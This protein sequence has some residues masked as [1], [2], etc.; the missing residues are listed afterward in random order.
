[1]EVAPELS[2]PPVG[3]DGVNE[4]VDDDEGTGEDQ[5]AQMVGAV[6]ARGV[7]GQSG[8]AVQPQALQVVAAPIYPAPTNP[9]HLGRLGWVAGV[10][11][12]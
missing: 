11:P 6:G 7:G 10:L 8:G 9:L 1:M 5:D 4:Q 2:D 3:S 12:G